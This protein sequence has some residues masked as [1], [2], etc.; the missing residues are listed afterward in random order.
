LH[1]KP[2]R[3]FF[4]GVG[5]RTVLSVLPGMSLG[6]LSQAVTLLEVGRLIKAPDIG[7]KTAGRLLMEA[8]GEL[9][10]DDEAAIG[11]EQNRRVELVKN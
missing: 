9:V 10:I 11:R 2:A 5:K 3:R 8:K 4:S 7:K 1:G 6:K